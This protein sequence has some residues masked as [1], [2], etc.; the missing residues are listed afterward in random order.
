MS[1]SRF[2]ARG[3]VI[4]CQ[5]S[6]AGSDKASDTVTLPGYDKDTVTLADFTVTVP[7]RGA[8]KPGP[9]CDLT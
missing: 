6:L 4:A 8:N 5:H 7:V 9:S 2:P 1:I 3:F